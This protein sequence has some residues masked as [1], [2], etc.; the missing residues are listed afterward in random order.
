M[1]LNQEWYPADT[2]GMSPMIQKLEEGGLPSL[3]TR[4]DTCIVCKFIWDE[5]AERATAE[6]VPGLTQADQCPESSS[7]TS[8]MKVHVS[9]RQHGC[10]DPLASMQEDWFYP[11]VQSLLGYLSPTDESKA[12]FS[13]FCD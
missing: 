13:D 4:V 9:Q 5:G 7:P 3:H 12:E 2:C 8:T 1:A 6:P 11:A 10:E